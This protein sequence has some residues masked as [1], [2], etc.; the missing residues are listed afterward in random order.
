[1]IIRPGVDTFIDDMVAYDPLYLVDLDY[2]YLKP[3]VDKFNQIYQNRLRKYTIT[4][5]LGEHILN[6]LP[7]DQFGMCLAYNYFNF[8]P[9]DIIK[10][11]LAEIYTKLKPGGILAM[12][13][14]DCDRVA[15]VELVENHYCC[16]TPGYLIRELA[17]NVGYEIA[18]DWHDNGPVTWLELR[19]PGEL[20]SLKGGQTLAEIVEKSK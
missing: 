11:Y 14:N 8:R 4:N 17:R 6:K 2:D 18:F 7:D 16:Y 9:L 10:K 1:M 12:T 19:R 5:D 13:F 15:A 3:A 20:T